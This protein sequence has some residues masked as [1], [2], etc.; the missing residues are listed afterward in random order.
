MTPS[1]HDNPVV[2]MTIRG[3]DL[4]CLIF[5]GATAANLVNVISFDFINHTL[6]LFITLSGGGLTMWWM[7]YRG[8][9][10][11]NKFLYFRDKINEEGKEDSEFKTEKHNNHPII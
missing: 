11:K 9:N 10:E 3:M 7:Y 6:Q 4:F 2:F 1:F 5:L 8:I